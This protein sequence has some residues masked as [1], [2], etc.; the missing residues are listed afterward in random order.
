M[1]SNGYWLVWACGSALFA[2]L[3]AIFAKMGVQDIDS[4]LATFIRTVIIVGILFVVVRLRSKWMNPF[5]LPRQTLIYL[6][7]SALA[8]G[9]SWICYF[10]AMKAGPATKVAAIDKMSLLLIAIFALL[11]LGERLTTKNWIGVVFMT[12]GVL[13]LSWK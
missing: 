1:D 5:H 6:A 8:T 10:R 9:A 3:T 2:A 13:F 4:D 7:I 12:I 11:F